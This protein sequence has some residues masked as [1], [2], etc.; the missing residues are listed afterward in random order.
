MSASLPPRIDFLKLA[1]NLGGDKAT[2]QQMLQLFLNSVVASLEKLEEAQSSHSIILWL[3]TA[4]KIKGASL[5]I[6]AKRLGMLCVEA[7]EIQALPHPQSAA[8]LYNMHK[9]LALLRE[10]IDEHLAAMP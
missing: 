3:Q 8:V 10:A 5:N 6:T 1:M 7:E 9:E 2:I 4:H